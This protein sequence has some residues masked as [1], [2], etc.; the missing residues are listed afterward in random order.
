MTMRNP[1]LRARRSGSRRRAYILIAVLGIST[2]A[3]SVGIA[4]LE[5]NSTS[6]PEAENRYY[7]MRAQYVAGSGVE[8]AKR[9]LLNPPDSVPMG[10]YWRGAS[11]IAIDAT[12]DSTSISVNAHATQKNRFRIVSQGRSLS[13]SSTRGKKSV[14]AEVI[15]PPTEVWNLPFGLLAKSTITIPSRARVVGNLHGNGAVTGLGYCNGAV[16]AC[17]T[18]LWLLGSGPPTSV[19]SLAPAQSAP[20]I[21]LS[22]YKSYSLRGKTYTAYVWDSNSMDASQAAALNAISMTSTNPGR[23][24]A[25]RDGNFR[26]NSD[27][28]F[29][30]TILVS[31]NLE[32]EPRVSVTA[33]VG[34]PGVVVTGDVVA[35]S[36]GSQ[37]TVNGAAIVGG[38][39]SDNNR[40]GARIGIRGSTVLTG[41]IEIQDSTSQVVLDWDPGRCWFYNFEQAA[42]REPITV[43]RWTED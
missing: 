19:R 35:Q 27:A 15:V 13:G 22:K 33:V 4:Y 21:T 34:F 2:V 14:R 32:F 3:A 10:D 6:I 25:V 30:G 16:S 38:K 11:N 20:A 7:A 24:I 12:S 43:V 29:N 37:L 42:T 39:L 41:S 23:I 8:L 28:N 5:A 40:S 26:F 31:G 1:N 36:N 17:G 18:A 9:Y